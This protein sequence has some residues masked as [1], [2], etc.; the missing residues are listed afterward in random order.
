MT[1]Q[2]IVGPRVKQAR[3]EQKPTLTQDD[4]AAKLQTQGWTIDRFG[5]SRIER[6]VR[7][8]TDKELLQLA[9]ALSVSVGYLVGEKANGN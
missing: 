8:V 5:V 6:G 2:N 1:S 7:Q 4:L 3:R 9:K